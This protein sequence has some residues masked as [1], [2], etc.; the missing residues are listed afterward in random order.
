MAYWDIAEMANDADLQ[1]R[2]QAAAAQEMPGDNP[3]Q[4][5]ND[6]MWQVTASPGWDAAW[7][8]AVAGNVD[9]PGKDPGVITDGQI[10]SAV[11]TVNGTI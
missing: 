10:L 3:A 1:A 9:R 2:V 4:W 5:I 6:H 7:A 11:Q 8:S